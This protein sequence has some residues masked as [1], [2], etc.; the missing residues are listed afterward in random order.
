VEKHIGNI[1]SKLGLPPSETDHR[2]V[3]AVLRHLQS[4]GRAKHGCQTIAAVIAFSFLSGRRGDYAQRCSCRPEVR[5]VPTFAQ[6]WIR[7]V[8]CAQIAGSQRAARAGS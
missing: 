8:V 1:F 7:G 6:V 2:R 4:R 3:L 5:A